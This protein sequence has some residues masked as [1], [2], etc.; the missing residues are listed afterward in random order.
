MTL[1]NPSLLYRALT[2]PFVN[3]YS[4]QTR[5][6]RTDMAELDMLLDPTTLLSMIKSEELKFKDPNEY[7]PYGSIGLL[8]IRNFLNL[9]LPDNLMDIAC[10]EEDIKASLYE[11]GLTSEQQS[12]LDHFMERGL[13]PWKPRSIHPS[14]K[15]FLTQPIGDKT[16]MD[17]WIYQTHDDQ[18]P[19]DWSIFNAI[20]YT[21]RLPLI[22]WMLDHPSAPSKELLD[23][24][25]LYGI[26]L[27]PF[28]HVG[29]GRSNSNNDLFFEKDKGLSV[30]TIFTAQQNI[31]ALK[32]WKER[33][34][35][36]N[37]DE[38]SRIPPAH[39]CT[40]MAFFRSF[41]ELGGEPEAENKQDE[42]VIDFWNKHLRHT[43]QQKVAREKAYYACSKE[44]LENMKK[45]PWNEQWLDLFKK[46]SGT[47]TEFLQRI[48]L[49]S[50]KRTKMPEAVNPNN[51][52]ESFWDLDLT[53]MYKVN[54]I[55]LNLFLEHQLPNLKQLEKFNA[56]APDNT[57]F[58]KTQ[59]RNP[60]SHFFQAAYASKDDF[61]S[62]LKSFFTSKNSLF[63]EDVVYVV[64]EMIKHVKLPE[65]GIY[66]DR[67]HAEIH[68]CEHIIQFSSRQT[69]PTRHH[70][71]DGFQKAVD[72]F[73]LL[74]PHLN[75]P[76]NDDPNAPTLAEKLLFMS[77]VNQESFLSLALK[78]YL[79][80]HH[81]DRAWAPIFMSYFPRLDS[82]YGWRDVKTIEEYQE[83]VQKEWPE[84]NELKYRS[85]NLP[86]ML[87]VIHQFKETHDKKPSYN[88][89]ENYKN[90]LNVAQSLLTEQ[91]LHQRLHNEEM[92]PLE[93]APVARKKRL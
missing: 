17:Q 9:R 71:L 80:E 52:Q 65:K 12:L 74:Y 63:H 22:R 57:H 50:G 92:G 11:K 6:H 10:R 28:E 5:L 66:A 87:Q 86:M 20:V 46:S 75:E 23:K 2:N 27:S 48:A 82:Y 88:Q 56:L 68:E 79:M 25:V 44:A 78:K 33:G 39:A 45:R 1:F 21:G 69:K 3:P 36:I 31:E 26:Y 93:G 73:K 81:P 29:C 47:K 70:E 18:H 59:V 37:Q 58:F 4:Q 19:V 7:G 13:D 16:P 24:H 77:P 15:H 49:Y 90:I 84:L 51:P 35:D 67:T 55:N 40:N 34:M 62:W 54:E 76:I 43:A 38:N 42:N 89:K 72:A 60:N 91:L 83:A 8:L 30:P 14:Q 41:V 32:I 85:K 64:Q 61:I 53:R